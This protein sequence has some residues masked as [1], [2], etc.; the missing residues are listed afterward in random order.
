MMCGDFSVA[1]A[2]WDPFL[3]ALAQRTHDEF[4][5]RREKKKKKGKR[6]RPEAEEVVVLE[7]DE[8]NN[9][10][11]KVQKVV[12][13]SEHDIVRDDRMLVLSE[14]AYDRFDRERA[15]SLGALDSECPSSTPFFEEESAG[16]RRRPR[17]EDGEEL[18]KRCC[19][20]S[21]N[22][23]IF[24]RR[25][26]AFKNRGAF[27]CQLSVGEGGDLKIRENRYFLEALAEHLSV[28]EVH[29]NR[30]DVFRAR[31]TVIL[32]KKVKATPFSIREARREK[33]EKH[34]GTMSE[35]A[36]EN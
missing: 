8:A 19:V 17:E 15:Y 13:P 22:G 2:S 30:E 16:R 21:S 9:V 34:F 18:V 6:R 25:K 36:D 4:K 11:Q 14:S 7:D 23:K 29:D 33:L 3:V 26:K 20:S 12:A 35:R 31:N 24:A 10:E 5:C 27:A 28:L 32:M 1:D